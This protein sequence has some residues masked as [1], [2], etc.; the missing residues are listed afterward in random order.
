MR[1]KDM[2]FCS[3]DQYNQFHI[4]NIEIHLY[5]DILSFHRMHFVKIK[6]VLA[7]TYAFVC[8]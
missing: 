8:I 5:I 1:E 4:L 6:L 3:G 7:D 2:V